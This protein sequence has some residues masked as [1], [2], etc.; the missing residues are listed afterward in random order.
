MYKVILG[1]VVLLIL[2]SNETFSQRS[3]NM[4][5]FKN[6][7]IG[8]V[9][10]SVIDAQTDKPVSYANVIIY[11]KSDSSLVSGGITDDDGKFNITEL[12]PGKFYLVVKFIGYKKYILDEL[13]ITPRKKNQD[14]GV[15]KLNHD[16][17]MTEAVEVTATKDYIEYKI[18]RKIVNVSEDLM[19]Q[20]GSAAEALENA[21]SVNVDIEGNVTLRGSS[22]FTVF[23]NGKPSVL[24]GSDALQQIPAATIERIELIT[25]PSAKY[26]PDG[27]SGIINVVLKENVK[28]GLNGV[29]NVSVGTRDKYKA[30]FL[31]KY[32]Y[33]DFSVFG[34]LDWSDRKFHGQGEIIGNYYEMEDA[35]DLYKARDVESTT[36]GRFSRSGYDLKGG[37]G[38]QLSDNDNI[39]L[40][41]RWGSMGYSREHTDKNITDYYD[42]DT[43]E[44]TLNITDDGRERDFYSLNL[45]YLH[46]FDDEGHMLQG[47]IYYSRRDALADDLQ[48]QFYTNDDW[49]VYLLDK[50]GIR[51][52]END[53]D[54]DWRI[55]LDYTLPLGEEERFEAGYQTR[56]DQEDS[57][58]LF[59]RFD[60]DNDDWVLD[61]NFSNQMNYRRDIHSLYAQY[62]G[63]IIGLDFMAGLRGEYTYRKSEVAKSDTVYS[64]DRLD[65]FPTLH[66]SRK[67]FDKDQIYTSYSRRI[68]RPRGRDLDP[69]PSYRNEYTI[70]LGNPGLEPEYVNSFELGYQKMFGKSYITLEGY[71][72]MTDNLITRVRT[73]DSGLTVHTTQNLNSDKSLG[74]ELSANL[75]LTDYLMV[76]GAFNY[77]HYELDGKVYEEDVSTSTESWNARLNANLFL[78]KNTRFQVSSFYRGD[79]ITAQGTRNGFL[80]L[81]V[82]LRQDLFDRQATVTLQAR[83]LLGSMKREMTSSGE[84]FYN[85][86]KFTRES[87]MIQL[88]FSY[89][90]NNYRQEKRSSGSSEGMED[91]NEGF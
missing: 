61:D 72:R 19:A 25:N 23:I 16:E 7:K 24:E 68:N 30:D 21:P 54:N 59:Y 47:L 70:R 4:E 64:I 82:A 62:T 8:T 85:Y 9:K 22:N 77:F 67:V 15:I 84:F 28:Q 45:D 10:G 37:I 51:S 66:L 12:P 52:D 48:N 42:A 29:V 17:V 83:D 53:I 79:I 55:K 1:I 75:F 88:T 56:I 14:L 80:T 60:F 74:T 69:Y 40:E 63:S 33:G 71:Y 90:I 49:S 13:T 89:K 38:W 35:S 39:T 11:N 2:V 34:G 44:Y 46:N 32:S 86:D 6:M 3:G 81:S 87:P 27:M 26:D 58:F 43:T 36:N 20:G 91:I 41:G 73:I 18:D 31:L 76:M 78:S 5:R 50:E 65:L 57:D